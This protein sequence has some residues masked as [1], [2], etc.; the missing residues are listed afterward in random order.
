MQ[1]DNSPRILNHNS[2]QFLTYC[3]NGLIKI[4][5]F[6]EDNSEL[7]Q[8]CQIN[9]DGQVM[10]LNFFSH[11][12]IVAAIAYTYHAQLKIW[13]TTSNWQ[14]HYIY[15]VISLVQPA[16]IKVINEQTFV[17]SEGNRVYC[18]SDIFKGYQHQGEVLFLKKLSSKHF[19]SVCRNK[20]CL[21]YPI[22]DESD[23]GT[24]QPY[25]DYTFLVESNLSISAVKTNENKIYCG[26]NNGLIQILSITYYNRRLNLLRS[27][28][29]QLP[30]LSLFIHDIYLFVQTNDGQLRVWSTKNNQYDQVETNNNTLRLVKSM[31]KQCLIAVSE[32]APFIEN[33]VDKLHKFVNVNHD[34][35]TIEL[36][37]RVSKT[38]GF[39]GR[40][41]VGTCDGYLL[42]VDDNPF[43]II[44]RKEPD[45]QNQPLNEITAIKLK[46]II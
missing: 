2:Q 4:W 17:Y 3:K 25:I 36:N 45:V 34:E 28:Q 1:T 20:R 35:Q 29:C 11:D 6:V 18:Y 41:L 8:L 14:E 39:N 9:T 37:S 40:A 23:D 31:S 30:I 26:Y 13:C 12:K 27:L 24:F 22:D 16:H 43:V 32:G 46:N 21:I 42:V 44:Q 15:Q 10:S 33:F 5:E 19:I 38:K 7:R